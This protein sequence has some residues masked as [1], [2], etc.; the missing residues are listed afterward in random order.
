MDTIT[1]FLQVLNP[2]DNS[3]GGG[4]ASALA[5]AMA[6]ALA[7][8]VA[9]LSVGKGAGAPDG[10]YLEVRT[11]GEA[12]SLQLA[13]RGARDAEAFA[14][15][16]AA[17]RLPKETAE[18][19]TARAG[20]PGGA[21]RCRAG[22]PAQCRPLRPGA[23]G[24]RATRGARKPE[25]ALG[26]PVRRLPRAGRADRLPGQCRDQPPGHQG[27]GGHV[28]HREA[29]AGAAGGGR[30][31]GGSMKKVLLCEPNISEGR[32]R[33]VFCIMERLLCQGN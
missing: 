27:P 7:A 29:G 6:A 3:T 26:L 12:L 31:N 33:P 16:R 5:G 14:A 13:A 22:A 21:D 4:K 15:V 1:A 25:R 18:Q 20:H 11:T 10:V 32:S 17:Y 30:V 8:M 2:D 19:K 28:R 9:R 23:G 24:G